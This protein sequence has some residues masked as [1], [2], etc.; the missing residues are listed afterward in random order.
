MMMLMG[1]TLVMFKYVR[2]VRIRRAIPVMSLPF[3]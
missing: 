2:H 3:D 1:E